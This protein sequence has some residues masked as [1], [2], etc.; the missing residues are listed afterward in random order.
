MLKLIYKLITPKHPRGWIDVIYDSYEKNG[1]T[2]AKVYTKGMTRWGMKDLEI[3]DVPQNLIGY[4]HG[5]LFELTGYMK[6]QKPINADENF[7]GFLIH[8]QQRL[9]NYATF[10][11]SGE[12]LRVVDLKAKHE[13]GFPKKLFASYLIE[14]SIKT[15]N[16]KKKEE[17]IRSAVEIFDDYDTFDEKEIETNYK[18]GHNVNNYGGFDRLGDL[19]LDNSD[20]KGWDYIFQAIARCPFYAKDLANDIKEQFNGN[21]PSD[22]DRFKFWGE[23]NDSKID[24]IKKM[25]LNN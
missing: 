18:N 9:A 22:D 2:L 25:I 11:S 1:S 20:D 24:E 13:T 10:R 6:N 17:E 5:I 7:G 23:L 19:L 21:Y 15:R 3:V 14:G 16:S 8:N 12:L 4:A